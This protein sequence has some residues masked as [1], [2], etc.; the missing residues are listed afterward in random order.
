MYTSALLIPVAL[1]AKGRDRGNC[2]RPP[3]VLMFVLHDAEI[4]KADAVIY[5]MGS[6]YTSICPIVCLEG[7]GEAIAARPVPKVRKWCMALDIGVVTWCQWM[8]V[9]LC[10]KMCG[11][12]WMRR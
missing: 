3:L 10:L 11:A 9:C 4:E 8:V 1:I 7:M 12:L 2:Q 5:G 6:L